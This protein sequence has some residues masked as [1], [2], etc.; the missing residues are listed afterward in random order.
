VY[1]S[2]NSTAIFVSD[3]LGISLS[4]QRAAVATERGPDE[5]WLGL[6]RHVADNHQV[7]DL[8]DREIDHI[9]WEYTAYPFADADYIERQLHELF[10]IIGARSS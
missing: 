9:L 7:S 1:E 2:S 6:V 8:T 4:L 5:T 10:S 3:L